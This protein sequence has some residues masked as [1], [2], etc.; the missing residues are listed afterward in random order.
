MKNL[1]FIKKI[2]CCIVA[3]AMLCGMNFGSGAVT[4]KAKSSGLKKHYIVVAENDRAYNRIVDEVGEEVIEENEVLSENNIMVAELSEEEAFLLNDK[5]D[6][7]VE[8]DFEL[9]A[10][11]VKEGSEEKK[12]IMD[13]LHEMEEA[14]I[15]N[16]EP[17]WN[18]QA[19]NAGNIADDTLVSQKVKV[20]VLDSGVDFVAGLDLAETV[21]L[22]EE[23]DYISVWYQDL[24]GHGTS[25]ASVISGNGEN[26]V[27]GVNPG[28]ELYSVKVLDKNNTSPVSRIIEGIYW[29]IEQEI[30]IIN[31]SFGTSTYSLALKKAVEDAYEANILMI[32]AAGNHAGDVEYPAAFDEV[33]AVAATDT[34]S[35]ISSFSNMGEEL[36]IA[37]PGEKIRVLGYFG[38]NGVT[39]G[40]SIAVPQ[41]AGVA[42]LLWERDLSKSNEFIRQ[43]ISYSAKDISN[44]E[45]CGLLDAQYALDVYD[46]FAENFDG[47]RVTNVNAVPEN[48]ELVQSYEYI[49]D[50]ENYVEGRWGGHKELTQ[51][52]LTSNGVTNQNTINVMKAGCVYPDNASSG[53]KPP[54][55][56]EFH[57]GYT[58]SGTDVNYIAVYEYITNIALNNGSTSGI[59]FSDT[60]GLEKEIYTR[61]KGQFTS[62]KVGSQKWDDVLAGFTGGNTKANRKYF[63]W[64]IALHALQDIFAHSTYQKSSG[65]RI[66]H[67][68]QFKDPNTQMEGAD[69]R[70][71]VP[72]RWLVSELATKDSIDCLLNGIYGDF[73]EIDYALKKQTTYT[74]PRN[75]FLK[76]RLLKYATSNSN[77]LTSAQKTRFTNYNIN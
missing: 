11:Q 58:L 63:T 41:V 4:S 5:K 18:L 69:K 17:E 65:L 22:V 15:E 23:E 62:T 68:F 31:M 45:E 38:L 53:M 46:D 40:T 51:N 66:V 32:G 61:V 39:H 43:L 48:I 6:V 30:N 75:L 8:E 72:S 55:Q 20:A 1:K 71:V 77:G 14:E 44:T 42:S 56:P 28:V 27:R 49:N 74:M 24:T 59:T 12:E 64:G 47:S 70:E 21:N 3:V 26:V 25:I 57:G 36:D 10:N 2:I 37:A 73:W 7:I 19:I 13:A 50:D 34:E 60:Y 33:M 52:G 54:K 9:E 76:K 35:E 16:A 29:C 67:D